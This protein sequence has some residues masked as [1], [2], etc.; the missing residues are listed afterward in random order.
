M[1]D[2]TDIFFNK[3]QD[4][5]QKADILEQLIFFG[6]Y[7][8]S[9][10]ETARLLDVSER[11]LCEKLKDQLDYIV[12]PK[13][14]KICLAP[15]RIARTFR[16]DWRLDRRIG[17]EYACGL[18]HKKIFIKKDSVKQFMAQT[19]T[20]TDW[21]WNKKQE[22]MV[23][24]VAP[25][26]EQQISAILKREIPVKSLQSIKKQCHFK[27]NTQAYRYVERQRFPKLSLNSIS[28]E[29]PLVRYYVD[30]R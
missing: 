10:S 24:T 23:Q 12:P 13:E 1:A 20:V 21:K 5:F 22:M 6:G 19:I 28:T 14:A 11:Y 29:K 17:F 27:H 16:E 18:L 9:V 7:E 30:Y 26:S 25:I 2:N 15:E 3:T 8:L 4:I